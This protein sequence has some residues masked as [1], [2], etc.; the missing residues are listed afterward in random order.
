MHSVSVSK[1]TFATSTST[2]TSQDSQSG[3]VDGQR[4][5]GFFIDLSTAI[6]TPVSLIPTTYHQQDEMGLLP[7]LGLL[8]KIGMTQTNPFEAPAIHIP[9]TFDDLNQGQ[10]ASPLSLSNEPSRSQRS[11]QPV[12]DVVPI[13]REKPSPDPTDKWITMSG[14]KKRPF[15]CGF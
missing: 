8:P 12:K 5:T 6:H 9:T 14:D 1:S 4:P 10:S 2:T 7:E 11:S 13:V 15:Q 3:T